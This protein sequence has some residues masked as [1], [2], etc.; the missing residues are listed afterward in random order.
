MI[1]LPNYFLADLPPEATISPALLGEACL[2][3]KRNR[4]QYLASRTTG[5]IVKVLSFVAEGWLQPDSPFR[6]LALADGPRH[7]GFGR[8][9]LERGLDNFFAK[10]T[11]E[12][13]RAWLVQELGDARRLDEFKIAPG[14]ER[15]S[16]AALAT[17][18]EFLAHVCAGHLPN[19]TWTSMVLGLLTRSAQFVKCASG[20]AFLPRLFAH[21]IYDA[22][23][24]LGACLEVAEWRGGHSALEEILFAEADCITA[25]GSDETLAA[26]RGK[27]PGQKRFLGSGHRVSFGYA[28][29]ESLS[30]FG[31]KRV[32]KAAATDVVAWNQLGCLSPHVIYVQRG[33]A[34]GPEQFAQLLAEELE[35]REQTEPRGAV[36]PDVAANITARRGIYEVRAAHSAATLLWRSQDSTAWTVVWEAAP[37]FSISCLHRFIYVKAVADLAE[38]LHGADAVRGQVSTVGLAADEAE[39]KDIATALARWG[40]TRVCP[41]GQMQN[42]PLTWRHDGRLALGDLVTWTDWEQ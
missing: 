17:G 5:Q 34:T 20:A 36:P 8:A 24:K 23:H 2:T 32:A 7:T 13:L 9:T 37:N 12:S 14:E 3:L 40:A 30:G 25:T 27:L 39:A 26:I 28:T 18:P 33:G 35:Q 22:D 10:L 1:S 6:E 15:F 41:L 31:G 29:S 38:A 16:R 19:P 4:E 11:S 21:S 42:P